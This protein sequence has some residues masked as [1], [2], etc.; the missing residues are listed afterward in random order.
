MLDD[1]SHTRQTQKHT[2]ELG[3]W[4]LTC[5]L[6]GRSHKSR[7]QSHESRIGQKD[8]IAVQD[9]YSYWIQRNSMESIDSAET[10]SCLQRFMRPNQRPWKLLQTISQEFVRAW[11]VLQRTHDT[12]TCDR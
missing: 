3:W 4:D 5:H 6:T 9:V 2:S 12:N 11:Q 7:P 10:A 8:P 1:Q